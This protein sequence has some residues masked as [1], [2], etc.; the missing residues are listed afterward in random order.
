MNTKVYCVYIMTNEWNTTFYIGFSSDLKSR[1]YVHREK[2]AEGFTKRYNL[3]KL[4]YYECGE[5]KEGALAR[6]KQ[7]K[8]WNRA[9]KIALIK[10]VNPNFK[11]LYDRL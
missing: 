6:E 1:A 11:D 2:I 9:K 4:V 3:T 5:D 8:H 7:L 10:K